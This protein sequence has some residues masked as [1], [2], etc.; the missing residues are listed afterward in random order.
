MSVNNQMFSS[1]CGFFSYSVL[2]FTFLL[3]F[4]L[5]LNPGRLKFFIC[6]AA[7]FFVYYDGELLEG[8][9]Q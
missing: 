3:L 2:L 8:P 7:F 5:F 9:F 4:G 1:F 6:S